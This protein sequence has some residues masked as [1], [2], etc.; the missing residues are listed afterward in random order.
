[1]SP[2]HTWSRGKIKTITRANRGAPKE[3]LSRVCHTFG[4]SIALPSQPMADARGDDDGLDPK[5]HS[6]PMPALRC[7]RVRNSCA[8]TFRVSTDLARKTGS[9][10]RAFCS[11]G[12]ERHLRAAHYSKAQRAFRKAVLC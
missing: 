10:H 4:H 6:P 2:Y 11:R 8:A 7:R 5:L 12:H 1:M 9:G 3:P